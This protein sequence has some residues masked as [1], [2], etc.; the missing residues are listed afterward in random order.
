MNK[1]AAVALTTATVV[2]IWHLIIWAEIPNTKNLDINPITDVATVKLPGASS[3]GFTDPQQIA[4]FNGARDLVGAPIGERRLSNFARQYLDVYAMILPYHISIVD[5]EAPRSP[6]Q[7]S[8][9][10]L[11]APET[12]EADASSVPSEHVVESGNGSNE[13]T[14][15]RFGFRLSYPNTFTPG[16]T[17]DNG[18]GISLTSSDGIAVISAAGSN[19]DGATVRDYY[20]EYLKQIGVP[21]SYSKIGRGWFVLSWRSGGKIS[22]AKM[23]VG[24]GSENSFSFE[25]PEDQANI[26]SSIADQL[27]KSFQHG[28]LSQAW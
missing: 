19:S 8:A 28:D 10:N 5:Q 9:Q 2:V 20:E 7:Q 17:P 26:Y 11:S 13:Y 6:Q 22:Y 18:D 16:R 12:A 14:N 25:Y 3:L 21:P 24:N 15:R 27:E 4:A 1:I 23:F